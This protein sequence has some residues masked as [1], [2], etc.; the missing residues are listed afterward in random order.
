M[1]SSSATHQPTIVQ[2][3]ADVLAWL[4]D[5]VIGHNLCPFASRELRLN[6]VRLHVSAATQ[7]QDLVDA[8]QAELERLVANKEIETALLIHPW[9]LQDFAQYNQFLD[10]ADALL[11]MMSLEGVIQIASFHPNYQFEGSD[12]DDPANYTNRSPY[13]LLH[14]LRED[15]V[16]KAVE[17]YGDSSMIPKRNVEHLE[18][19]GIDEVRAMTA[20]CKARS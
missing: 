12:D 9:V 2:I 13:P 20:R 11:A 16:A 15:S 8:L 1:T 19:L 3:E 17:Q 7:P 14:L 6:R 4:K 18:A 5:I 10:I